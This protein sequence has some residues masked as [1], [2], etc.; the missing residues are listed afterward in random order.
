M[1]ND[2]VMVQVD[3]EA[4]IGSGQ[5][6]MLEEATF[7]L[8]EDSGISAVVGT[9]LLPLDRAEKIIDTCPARAISRGSETQPETADTPLSLLTKDCTDEQTGI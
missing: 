2:L 9:G 8:D 7:L 4:C 6:E 1:S 5:C 3:S